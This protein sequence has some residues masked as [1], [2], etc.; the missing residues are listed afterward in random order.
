MKSM[1]VMK[2]CMSQEEIFNQLKDEPMLK[3][4]NMEMLKSDL[5]Y[6]VE[7]KNLDVMQH[8]GNVTTIEEKIPLCLVM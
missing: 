8:V 1:R 5:D 2:Y 6:L 4:Y 7:K 3:E